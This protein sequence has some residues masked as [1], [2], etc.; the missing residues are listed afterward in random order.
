MID[1]D[2]HRARALLVDGNPMM[3]SVALG[4]LRDAGVGHIDTAARVRDARMMLERDRYDIVLC[5]REFEGSEHAGQDLLDELRRENLLPHRTVF[6][7]IANRAS[8]HQ[9]V[10][11]AESALD[12]MLL[13]PYTG[14]LLMQRLTEAR[15]RKRELAD[16]MLALD[17]G[18]HQTAFARAYKR[19]IERQP[20][21]VYC[22]RVAAE[23]LLDMR[24]F[25][26]A[27]RV[28]EKLTEATKA[29]WAR[30]GIARAQ[31]GAGNSAGA[32]E[33]VHAVLVEEP[34]SADAHDLVGRLLIDQGDFEAAL[35]SYRKAAELTPG[36]LLRTQHAG[37]LAFYQG[38]TREARQLFEHCLGLGV[39]SKLFDALTL[40]LLA[41]VR[42]DEGD[43]PGAAA[44]H[45][46]LRE[47]QRRF[48]D[49]RRLARLTRCAEVLARLA[50]DQG[51]A[52]LD[53]LR[54]IGSQAGDD[55]FDL[56]S[57]NMLLALWSRLPAELCPNDEYEQLAE[58]IGMRFCISRAITE[59]LVGAA[60][61]TEPALGMIRRCQARISALAEQAMA[62]AMQGEAG[63]AAEHL[64]A[65]GQRTLNGRLLEMA[66]LI[67]SR[68][69]EHVVDAEKLVAR[70]ATQ[71]QRSCRI[72]GHIAG[73][74]R[75][76][77]SP[78]GL[79]MRS[80]QVQETLNATA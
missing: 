67:A 63:A 62:R 50:D 45:E 27:Q 60:R 76:G 21:A 31:M 64:L 8:Y 38:R 51:A 20:Y 70:A 32:R 16:I 65:I 48:P 66:G 44:M 36:C 43:R 40:L 75:T 77:R 18:N 49:S 7:M 33:T 6:L 37:A 13:R 42:H 47:F 39:Q 58:R 71:I 54:E 35:D 28:F 72:D 9:V 22:G 2:I 17:T 74:Q 80:R 5:N 69:R 52:A 23:L 53:S 59:S 4:Q 19:F 55:D 73:I 10:E 57:A 24:R 1:R 61:G 79:L 30:L 25:V 3:R 26:E 46:Q 12:G 29:I 11:A 56:E 68:H 41:L 78:G 15:R 34:E 14:A